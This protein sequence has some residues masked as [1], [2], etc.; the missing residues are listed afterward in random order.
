M[1]YQNSKMISFDG[2][3]FFLNDRA[4]A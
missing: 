2:G 4:A 1:Q 3:A